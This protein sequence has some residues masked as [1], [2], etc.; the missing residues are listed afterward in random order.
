[1][2]SPADGITMN[3]ER[4]MSDAK[5]VA[6]AAVSAGYV[7]PMPRR[8]IP[9]GGDTVYAPLAL[10]VYLAWRAGRISAHDAVIGRALATVMAGGRMPHGTTVTEQHLLDLEREAFLGLVAQART[11]DRIRHT[12]ET[13]TPLRN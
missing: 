8:A 3:R 11:Q 10:A 2:L 12:L 13:G 7:A 5:T 4:L 9:V 6:L 1:M